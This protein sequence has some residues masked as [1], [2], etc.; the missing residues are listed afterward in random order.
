MVVANME[1]GIRAH[2]LPA[3]NEEID[4]FKILSTAYKDARRLKL[5]LHPD[6]KI[7]AQVIRC[8]RYLKRLLEAEISPTTDRRIHSLR[9]SELPRV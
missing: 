3:Q 4:S 9:E 6:A 2:L 1:K 7:V 8:E 5:H